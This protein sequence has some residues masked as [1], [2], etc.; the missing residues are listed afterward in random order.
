MDPDSDIES[1]ESNMEYCS[2][3][4]DSESCGS[5]TDKDD[6]SD[7]HE[8]MNIDKQVPEDDYNFSFFEKLL[9]VLSFTVK[10]NLPYTAVGELLQSTDLFKGENSQYE[11]LG[12]VYQLRKYMD[13]NM[14]RPKIYYLCPS[15]YCLGSYPEEDVPKRC[16]HENC[17]EPLG[18]QELQKKGH[19]FLYT[20]LAAQIKRVLEIVEMEQILSDYLDGAVLKGMECYPNSLKNIFSS[21]RSVLKSAT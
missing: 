8:E 6:V 9:G 16:S 17:N 21:K 4:S 3:D 11:E 18:I 5:T 19:F 10:H 15:S 20:S 14:L 1:S 13:R 12:S 2:S 7:S